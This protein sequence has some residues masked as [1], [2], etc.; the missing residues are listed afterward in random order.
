MKGKIVPTDIQRTHIIVRGTVQGVGFRYSASKIARRLGLSG[1]V[2]NLPDGSVE[3]EAQGDV[4]AI[5]SYADWLRQGPP[6]AAVEGIA[7]K[8]LPP[9][10]GDSGFEI[11]H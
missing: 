3:T 11:E 8:P 5:Q 7:S 4:D 9:V 10:E 6:G 1:F 2:R